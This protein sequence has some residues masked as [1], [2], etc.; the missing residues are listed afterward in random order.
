MPGAARWASGRADGRGWRSTKRSRRREP[1]DVDLLDLD[2]ALSELA[3][4]DPRKSRF[5]ELNSSA[6]SRSTT[7]RRRWASRARRSSGTGSSLALWLHRRLTRRPEVMTPDRW[8][9]VERLY[10]AARA[11]PDDQRAAFLAEACAG[12]R[13]ASQAEVESMLAS[14]PA[15]AGFMSTPAVDSGM[16]SPAASFVGRQ[17]GPYAIQSPLGAGG[18]GEV[19]RARDSKLGRDVA[20]KILPR[21]FTNDPDRLA[22]FEREARLLASLNH[23]NIG[24]IYGLEDVDG[25]PALVLEL[26]EGDTLAERLAREA[27]PHQV[28]R[29]HGTRARSG[30]PLGEALTIARQIA[31][32]LEAAHEKGIVHRDLKPANI[33]ITPAGVV[34]VLDF[35]LA[36]FGAGRAG[37]TGGA[38]GQMRNV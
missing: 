27:G 20:I 10:H 28:R 9:D 35:G 21:I 24:A 2:A 14:E 34:K 22:R 30:L 18:M 16:L 13:R 33:K 25:I 29:N 5:V 1:R 38:A 7:V 36:K 3:S 19:Y 31:D 12:G 32:A 6:A 26:V 23:P 8:S 17:L 15:A 11:R 37:W 4:F